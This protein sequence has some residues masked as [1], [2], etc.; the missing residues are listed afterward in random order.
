MSFPAKS[1]VCT[2]ALVCTQSASAFAPALFSPKLH[3]H[4]PPLAP[5]PTPSAPRTTPHTPHPT[6]RTP[7]PLSPR[8]ALNRPTPPPRAP[9]TRP[10]P[11]P[12]SPTPPRPHTPRTRPTPRAPS[13]RHRATSRDG[14][15]PCTATKA[16]T[17]RTAPRRP[18]S[19]ISARNSAE[20]ARHSCHRSVVDVVEV[21]ARTR[22][23]VSSE[24][25][26]RALGL[27]LQDA[28]NHHGTRQKDEHATR[29]ARNARHMPASTGCAAASRPPRGAPPPPP[30][31]PRSDP[32][33]RGPA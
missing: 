10:T 2:V 18:R 30:R 13:P 28:D 9:A 32:R 6:T 29:A 33:Q 5:R 22:G 15:Q 14:K 19:T 27:V 16:A 3:H 11:S 20:F 21:A 17:P 25:V 12:H 7:R 8:P 23:I 4:R 31:G 26:S 24:S 1:S